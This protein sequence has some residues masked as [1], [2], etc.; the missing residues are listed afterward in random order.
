MAL[1]VAEPG[2]AVGDVD[3]QGN[4]EGQSGG[5]LLGNPRGVGLGLGG[6]QLEDELVVDLEQP[7]PRR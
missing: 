4:F 1:F 7:A 2:G 6:G 5:H 3:L